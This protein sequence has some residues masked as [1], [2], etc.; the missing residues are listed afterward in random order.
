MKLE[1]AA[2]KLSR[3]DLYDEFVAVFGGE[4]SAESARGWLADWSEAYRAGQSAGE[5]LIHPARRTLYERG[6]QSQIEAD[7]AAD[8]L[9]LLLYTWQACLKNLPGDSP[10]ADRWITFLGQRQMASP[11]EFAER[12]RQ[13][14]A[15]VD[16]A[17]DAVEVW[18]E[19]NGA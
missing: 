7:R 1:A 10:H 19:K 14:Q 2:G 15:Y 8:A 18:A 11:A 9:W 13:A 12:L 3:A 5:E 16:R 17:A 4:Q 6:F